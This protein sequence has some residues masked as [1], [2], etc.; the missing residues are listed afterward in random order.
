MSPTNEQAFS[1]AV[2]ELDFGRMVYSVVYL[3]P[4]VHRR[5]GGGTR[6]R[7]IG[8]VGDV[9]FRGGVIPAGGGRHYIL[10]S[11]RFLKSTGLAVGDS[12]SVR[13]APDDPEA[14]ELVPEF[15]RIL[16]AHPTASRVWQRLT[17]GARRRFAHRVGS[18]KQPA[19]RRARIEECIDELCG[20]DTGE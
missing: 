16:N 20:M 19:T 4:T 15:E 5:L 7:V 8:T 9:P 6:L 12:T 2:E 11:K 17:P 13:L 14:V 10:L 18:A 1:A 3:P